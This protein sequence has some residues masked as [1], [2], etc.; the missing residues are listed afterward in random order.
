MNG[1]SESAEEKPILDDSWFENADAY[2]GEKLVSLGKVGQERV[3]TEL[4][5]QHKLLSDIVIK[6]D[7]EE[8]FYQSLYTKLSGL[9][10]LVD[11]KI[12]FYQVN[13]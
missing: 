5:R 3:M 6:N 11:E 12:S 10:D 2:Q 7:E 9:R 1:K 13:S 4:D 8:E